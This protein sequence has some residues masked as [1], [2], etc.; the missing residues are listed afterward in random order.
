MA[1]YSPFP[2]LEFIF[3][4]L[5]K[6]PMNVITERYLSAIGDYTIYLFKNIEIR[7]S[8]KMNNDDIASNFKL[9]DWMI[10]W[11][12]NTFTEEFENI[13]YS[14]RN[15][16][17]NQLIKIAKISE[18]ES[19]KMIDKAFSEI[20]EN[21]NSI[22]SMKFILCCY[23]ELKKKWN[24][25]TK[26][27]KNCNISSDLFEKIITNLIKY[28]EEVRKIYK[29]KKNIPNTMSYVINFLL[30]KFINCWKHEEYLTEYF[31]FIAFLIKINKG[32]VKFTE[33]Q[34]DK[35]WDL[36]VTHSICQEEANFFYKQ[37]KR[38]PNKETK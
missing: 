31:D 8:Q 27:K 24:T 16:A 1:N 23:Q 37:L 32:D 5:E 36:F 14:L 33:K 25:K 30:Q 18:F 13:T 19:I 38:V 29:E 4:E 22:R 26:I 34:L 10:L 35:L 7:Q 20:N 21:S 15:L 12:I 11:N 6:T 3:K 28:K 9:F 2:I 17:V